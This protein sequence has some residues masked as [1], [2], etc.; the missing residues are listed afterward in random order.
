[1]VR[2]LLWLAVAVNVGIGVG[3]LVDPVGLLAPVGVAALDD[4][5]V[6]ELRA[7]YG[8]FEIGLGLFIAWCARAPSRWSAGLL[9]AVLTVGGL[10]AVRAASWLALRPEGWLL[11]ALC[12]VELGASAVGAAV[13]WTTYG[14]EA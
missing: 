13:W 3:C 5:G 7:M 1:M 8:G 9:A 6:V 14:R 12:A 2:V 4:R 11:P 10:G